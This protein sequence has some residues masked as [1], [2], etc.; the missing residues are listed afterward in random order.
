MHIRNDTTTGTTSDTLFINT[1]NEKKQ[2]KQDNPQIFKNGREN[3]NGKSRFSVNN[4]K[5]YSEPL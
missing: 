1:T 2:E 5:D 3:V 4:D